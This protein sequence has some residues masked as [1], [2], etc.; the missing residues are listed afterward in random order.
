MPYNTK[1]KRR[2]HDQDPEVMARKRAHHK[3]YRQDPEAKKRVMICRQR[4]EIK[5]RMQVYMRAYRLQMEYGI[6][7][8]EFESVLAK[9]GSACA[10]CGSSKWGKI[11]PVVDHDHTSG[12][13]RGILCSP[14]NIAAGILGDDPKRAQQLADYLR[15]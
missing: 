5:K 3:I 1:E 4:P 6:T 14:C 13:V 11:G 8:G 7:L 9:Q 12:V 10:A 2:A 15:K